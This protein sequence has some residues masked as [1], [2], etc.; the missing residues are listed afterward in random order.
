MKIHLNHPTPEFVLTQ[1]RKTSGVWHERLVRKGSRTHDVAYDVILSGESGRYTNQRW[2][3]GDGVEAATWDQWGIYLAVIFEADPEAKC[4]GGGGG[5]YANAEDFHRKTGGRFERGLFED[6]VP[7][8]D[9]P[10][11]L[12]LSQAS[13]D[14]KITAHRWTP[15][16][17]NNRPLSG[18]LSL[19][20]KGHSTKKNKRAECRAVLVR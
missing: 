5:G 2:V 19:R 12:V 9:V 3:N 20:C 6:G 17:E 13:P 14:Y 16:F 11:G 1:A 7:V 4:V 18:H 15:D 8:G 10:D